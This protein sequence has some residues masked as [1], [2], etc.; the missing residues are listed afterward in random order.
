MWKHHSYD[1]FW[2]GTT[3]T[4]DLNFYLLEKG[5]SKPAV[6]PEMSKGEDDKP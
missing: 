4:A 3:K 2:E 5:L 6:T 1:S